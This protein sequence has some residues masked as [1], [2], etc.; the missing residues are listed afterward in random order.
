MGDTARADQLE[1]SSFVVE[2]Y[3]GGLSFP[4]KTGHAKFKIN[5]IFSH[6]ADARWLA[7]GCSL[8]FDGAVAHLK[9]FADGKEVNRVETPFGIR[10]NRLSRNLAPAYSFFNVLA[11]RAFHP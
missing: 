10:R 11:L 5:T 6:R 3:N 7:G 1:D 4:Q 8:G 2:F 9:I